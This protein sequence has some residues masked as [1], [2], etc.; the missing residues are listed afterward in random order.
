M[1][2]SGRGFL[3]SNNPS[4][5]NWYSRDIAAIAE[6]RDLSDTA[7]Y[8]IDADATPNPGRYPVGGLTKVRFHNNHL[9]YA[10]T[11]FALSLMSLVAGLFLIREERRARRG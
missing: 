9:V 8:F 4:A 7:H 3:R 10:I 2:E 1:S 5:N 11:W 6:K